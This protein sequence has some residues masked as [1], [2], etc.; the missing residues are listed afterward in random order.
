M[1]EDGH[2]VEAIVF[3]LAELRLLSRRIRMT[4]KWVSVTGK[5]SMKEGVSRSTDHLNNTML[6][7]GPCK[8]EFS[9]WM[10]QFTESC[11]S[12]SPQKHIRGYRVETVRK[13]FTI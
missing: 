10:T 13:I 5:Q 6:S 9:I 7:S 3:G 8:V 11:R 12:L 2:T 4:L 1:E